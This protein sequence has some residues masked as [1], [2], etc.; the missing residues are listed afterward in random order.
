[1]GCFLPNLIMLKNSFI[2]SRIKSFGYAFKGLKTMLKEEPNFW[3]HL[4]AALMVISAGF[5]F[6]ITA[7]EWIAVLFAIAMVLAAEIFN[8]A[9]ENLSDAITKE[10]NPHIKK[11]KD[12]A[13]AAVLITTIF[14]LIIGLIIFLPKL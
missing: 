8:T 9:I 10:Q 11:T 6:K 2:K 1:M 4:L 14:A 13:A 7:Y 12:L 5:W 3:I